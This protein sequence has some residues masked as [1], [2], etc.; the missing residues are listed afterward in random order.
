MTRLEQA[1]QHIHNAEYPQ[2]MALAQ[3]ILRLGTQ[4]AEANT[5]LGVAAQHL[6][7]LPLAR[8]A[9]QKAAN[10]A[11]QSA[12]AWANLGKMAELQKDAPAALQAFT[13]AMRLSPT[14]ENAY[15]LAL[16]HTHLGQPQQALN[17]LN[18]APVN[19][20]TESLRFHLLVD[21]TPFAAWPA[22]WQNLPLAH[23][24]LTQQTM[25][26]LYHTIWCW[27]CGTPAEAHQSL[28]QLTALV[29][30]A[31]AQN[32]STADLTN[33]GAYAA[34]FQP[35]FAHPTCPP[36]D[37]ALAKLYVLGDSHTLPP[38]HQ[39]ATLGG[40]TFQLESRLVMG[41]TL[42]SLASPASN[43]HRA[44]LQHHLNTLPEDA[45]ILLSLGE[46]DTR[47]DAG[48]WA[49]SRKY[50][51]RAEDV[52]AQTFPPAIAWLKQT[53]PQCRFIL[54]NL[55]ALPAARAQN[56]DYA[57]FHSAANT[58]LSTLA[59]RHNLPLADIHTQTAPSPELLLDGYHLPPTGLPRALESY[60]R[61]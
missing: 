53:Y 28:A 59:S 7:Q 22:G 25:A 44:A 1:Q 36:E 41:A 34:F 27:A 33:A 50:H 32:L 30:A 42:W 15:H 9:F 57:A 18:A 39:C 52:L 47:E 51:K 55:P 2:A 31:R 14:A 12:E 23:W 56:A 11:P 49:H 4:Q 61:P 24:N 21:L 43:P 17:T 48:I 60:L 38:H 37:P 26:V 6:G 54:Q 35:L 29:A 45:P 16:A 10:L 3:K 5:I 13:H 40:T 46:I 20:S 8:T 58:L 19:L